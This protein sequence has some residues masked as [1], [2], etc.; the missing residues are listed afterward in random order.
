MLLLLLIPSHPLQP[1]IPTPP[2]PHHHPHHIAEPDNTPVTPIY[3]RTLNSHI[4][5]THLHHCPPKHT[6]T[7]SV[8]SQNQFRLILSNSLKH[9]YFGSHLDATSCSITATTATTTTAAETTTT[10]ANKRGTWKNVHLSQLLFCHLIVTLNAKKELTTIHLL[11]RDIS[12]K[13]T[14]QMRT[15]P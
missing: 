6:C 15:N 7:A 5:S 13:L 12:R 10:T 8:P 9:P 14:F 2:H 11:W 1:T 4:N 3:S